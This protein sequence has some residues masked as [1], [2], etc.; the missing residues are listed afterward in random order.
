MGR[1]FFSFKLLVS[2]CVASVV[3]LGGTWIMLESGA[4]I[5]SV[6]VGPWV[7]R[8]PVGQGVAN[9]YARAAL[10]R[11]GEIPI[12]ATEAI[13]FVART[14]AEGRPLSSACSYTL[15]SDRIIARWWTL[16]VRDANGELIDNPMRRHSFT[17]DNVVREKDGSFSVTLSSEAAPGNWLPSGGPGRLVL[18][19][20]LYDTPLYTN[21]ALQE[22]PLPT[23][24]R[25][26]C[27]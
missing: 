20:R 6:Q 1:I 23:I 9:P 19:L 12:A 13:T 22:S 5:E 10:A 17:S 26:A 4:A 21:G 11:S 25:S 8:L 16:T 27:A 3:G 14:D 2:L 18:T 7:S 24:S 15:N